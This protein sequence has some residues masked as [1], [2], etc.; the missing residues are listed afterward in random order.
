MQASLA[1]SEWRGGRRVEERR[2]EADSRAVRT[3][4]ASAGLLLDCSSSKRTE[5][6]AGSTKLTM[7][8]RQEEPP[9]G[10]SSGSKMAPFSPV[11]IKRE[12]DS[13][14]RRAVK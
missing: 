12:L 10:V 4:E 14:S 13:S 7:S 3:S 6:S 9:R 11:E 2:G 8:C 5:P 1:L